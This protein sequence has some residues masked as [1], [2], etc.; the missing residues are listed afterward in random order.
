[1]IREPVVSGQFYPEKRKQLLETIEKQASTLST[2][3]IDALG[4][5]LPHAG[6]YYSGKVA[7]T[8]AGAVLPKKRIIMLGPNHTGEGIQFGLWEKGSWV[9]P[10]AT[11]PIDEELAAAILLKG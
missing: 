8:T 10:L 3:K 7:I 1:M 5:I 2:K 6:Y 9:T 4:I 11:I